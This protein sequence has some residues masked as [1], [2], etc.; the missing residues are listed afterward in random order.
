M[1]FA[2]YLFPLDRAAAVLLTCSVVIWRCWTVDY[3]LHHVRALS[4]DL[5]GLTAGSQDLVGPDC[6]VNIP[7]IYHYI[8]ISEAECC[9]TIC[10]LLFSQFFGVGLCPPEVALF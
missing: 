7:Y 10:L 1:V 2:K 8:Y 3:A 4:T 9:T 6:P 5:D